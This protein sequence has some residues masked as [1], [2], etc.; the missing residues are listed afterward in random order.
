MNADQDT[1]WAFPSTLLVPFDFRVV[2]TVYSRLIDYSLSLSSSFL[3]STCVRR[4][5]SDRHAIWTFAGRSV[6]CLVMSWDRNGRK[7]R[8]ERLAVA[9]ALRGARSKT[10][11]VREKLATSPNK[12]TCRPLSPPPK[13]VSSSTATTAEIVS[14]PSSRA[15]GRP[16]IDV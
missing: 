5:V 13:F 2:L 7:Q 1:F 12:W 10:R 8:G 6:G 4:N 15:A 16:I 11:C 9:I 3:A 14:S